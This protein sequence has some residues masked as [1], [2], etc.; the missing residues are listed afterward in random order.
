M[1]LTFRR[2]ATTTEPA[3]IAGV[4]ELTAA[5]QSLDA[6]CLAGL[7]DG[8]RAMEDGDLTRA[9][10][11]VTKPVDVTTFDPQVVALGELFNAML[12]KAQ[13]ALEAYNSMRE[14]LRAA[15]GDRSSL[16]D[17]QQRLD[18]L[19][20]RCLTGLG[21]GLDAMAHGDL[22][23]DVVPVTQPLVA[24][25]GAQVG[26]LGERFNIMLG[27]AQ[28]GLNSYNNTREHLAGTLGEIAATSAAVARASQEMTDTAEQ[29]AQA[30]DEI[31]RASTEV[32]AGAEQ[33]V[34]AVIESQDLAREAFGVAGGT[35]SAVEDGVAMAARIAAIADQTNL[36]A[37]NAAIEAARAGE[38]GRGFAVVADEV[39]KLAESASAA[40]KETEKAFGG[41]TTSV[42]QVTAVIARMADA[43]DEVRQVA[44]SAS[45]ATEQVSASAEQSS[46]STAQ[47]TAAASALADRARA[48]DALVGAF[49]V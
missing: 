41:V 46:A 1:P 6:N 7:V 43:T 22:T 15:L 42:D 45:A 5:L 30:I 34:A 31:A 44:E 23:V 32:A 40:V 37:L 27:Q 28:A 49:T 14:E 20:D 29:T 48:L 17:L 39:R 11:P 21:A 19:S 35:A 9:A 4:A 10:V 8:L 36:L 25:H 38:A 12:G 3:P 24:A 13:G 2:T 33:Q 18:S 26:A 47:V 16:T